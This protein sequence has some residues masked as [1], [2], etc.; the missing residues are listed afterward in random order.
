MIK[1]LVRLIKIYQFTLSPDH[2]VQGRQRYLY[3]YCRFVPS[4]SEYARETLESRGIAGL[5]KIICRL[6]RCNPFSRPAYDPAIKNIR[7]DGAG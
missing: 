3:G 6:I 2:S 5:G 4:C 7:K 1:F